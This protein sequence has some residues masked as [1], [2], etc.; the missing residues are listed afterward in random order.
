MIGDV[1]RVRATDTSCLRSLGVGDL[2]CGDVLSGKHTL[3]VGFE[4]EES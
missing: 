3:G 2:T 1:Y 4:E